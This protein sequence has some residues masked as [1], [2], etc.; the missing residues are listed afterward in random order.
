MPSRGSNRSN[1][2]RLMDGDSN[3]TSDHSDF[4]NSFVCISECIIINEVI[5]FIFNFIAMN[6]YVIFRILVFILSH[7]LISRRI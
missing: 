1:N 5:G 7:H 6:T 2:K 4:S 3:P